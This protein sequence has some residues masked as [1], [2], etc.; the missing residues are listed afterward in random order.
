MGVNSPSIKT[1]RNAP[2]PGWCIETRVWIPAFVLCTRRKICDL[3]CVRFL[4]PAWQSSYRTTPQ[5]PA[6]LPL[7]GRK[8]PLPALPACPFTALTNSEIH[9]PACL[10][11][12]R[13]PRA[14]LP[15]REFGPC[16]LLP[17]S[18][19]LHASPLL[20]TAPPS[21]TAG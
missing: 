1:Y 19:V 14:C 12:R 3:P 18:S 4:L 7:M 17:P 16:A 21:K 9:L 2:G 11:L 13:A 6:C 20:P 8:V 10:A 5:M 15:R